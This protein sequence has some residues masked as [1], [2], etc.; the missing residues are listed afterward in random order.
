[1]AGILA[2]NWG[3][4]SVFYVMGGLSLIWIVLW[5]WLAQDSPNKQPLMSAE[6]RDFITTSLGSDDSHSKTKPK[7]AVPWKSVFTSIPFYGILVAHV[8]SNFGWYMLLI[9]LPF[10]M[11]QV[12]K[13]NIKDN[14]IATSV[15]F[16]TMWLF[17][18]VISRTLDSLK[19]KGKISTTL[20]RKIATLF[21]SVVPMVCLLILC[22][23][24][25][26][27]SWAVV[28]VGIGKALIV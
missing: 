17:S 21:A 4:A 24:G 23:I 16:L 27:R 19:Q 25:C 18:M 7:R 15:P 6:E 2:E 22:F 28:I 3:W 1:M 11:K 26:E 8:C 14:A 20:A 5:I 10:Y 9:E 13:F 12:L